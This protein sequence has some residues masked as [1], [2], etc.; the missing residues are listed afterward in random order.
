MGRYMFNE[1]EKTLN[2]FHAG[3]LF[4]TL[5][6]PIR[7]RL[8]FSTCPISISLLCCPLAGLIDKV[9]ACLTTICICSQ[10]WN[11]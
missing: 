6:V 7:N 11:F 5:L 2:S 4:Y 3:F 1:E 10:S 9:S 8:R